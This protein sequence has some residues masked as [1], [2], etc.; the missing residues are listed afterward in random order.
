MAFGFFSGKDDFAD[1]IYTGGT[2]HT[3]DDSMP[4]A[5]AVACK[6]GMILRVGTDE[7]MRDIIGD[8]T[9]IFDLEGMHMFP[10]F[11]ETDAAPVLDAIDEDVCFVINEREH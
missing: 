9:E 3:M 7:D 8:D 2:I 10:G 5:D 1:I 4:L 6:G 11:I